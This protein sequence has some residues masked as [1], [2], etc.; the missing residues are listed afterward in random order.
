VFQRA[1]G[2][3][4]FAGKYTIA[5]W[6]WELP[7]LP[8]EWLPSFEGIDELW[9]PSRFIQAAVSA[10]ARVPVVLMPHAISLPQVHPSRARF[11]LPESGFLFL[12][13]YD[14]L[15]YQERKNPEAVV[16]AFRKAF[17][18]RTDAILVIKVL[19]AE[20][21]PDDMQRLRESLRDLPAA[22]LLPTALSRQAVYDLEA[23]CDAFV[24]LHRAEGFGLGLAECMFLGKPVIGTNWSGNT[25]F[26]TSRNSCPVDGELVTLTRDHGPYRM[27]QRWAEPDIDQAASFMRALVDDPAYAAKIGAAARATMLGE[28]A[29]SVIGERYQRR[30]RLLSLDA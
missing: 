13:M 7:E 30:L 10:K 14:L 4:F 22:V 11:G 25:D 15:S 26:M 3:E 24:S 21:C 29:P 9:A 19:N 20:R 6:H 28:H 18:T 16:R 5:C 17:A 8:D 2:P 27:G 12:T 23:T 1:M